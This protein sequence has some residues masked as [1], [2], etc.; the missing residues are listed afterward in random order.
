MED[1]KLLSE[2]SVK[3]G[4]RII[5]TRVESLPLYRAEKY[6]PEPY[7]FADLDSYFEDCHF[8]LPKWSELHDSKLDCD[9]MDRFKK[10]VHTNYGEEYNFYFVQLYKHSCERFILTDTDKR[11][12][13]WDSGIVGFCAI[14]KHTDKDSI[15]DQMTDIWE[16]TIYQYNIYNNETDDIID[17][18][19]RWLNYHTL[20]EWDDMCSEAKEKYGVN[21]DEIE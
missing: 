13:E 9:T 7:E 20:K 16:G 12:D 18:Y 11:V 17:T 8:C 2:T 10:L 6:V 1:I 3:D 5:R 15:G 21:L 4:N 19:E 14:P